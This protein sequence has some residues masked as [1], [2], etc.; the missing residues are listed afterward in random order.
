EPFA[1][2]HKALGF[3]LYLRIA[4]E[5]YLR[6]L[7]VGGFNRVFELNRNFRKEGISRKHNPAFTML[8]AYWAYADFGKIADLLAEMVC[9][10]AEVLEGRAPPRPPTAPS[11]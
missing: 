8:E 3:D 9:H 2:R 5:L 11:P 6:R 10:V 1:T 4:P 7:L